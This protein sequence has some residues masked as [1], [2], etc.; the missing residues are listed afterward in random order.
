[1]MR[2]QIVAVGIACA[3]A[4][5]LAASALSSDDIQAQ[6]QALLA[7]VAELQQQLRV[8]QSASST[9]SDASSTDDMMAHPKL[10]V[11]S[12]LKRTLAQGAQGDDVSGLQ[13]YLI[14]GG[15]LSASSTGY[16][17]PLTARAVAK[18]QADEGVDS[19]G[20]FGPLSREH[21][22]IRCGQPGVMP[23]FSTSTP[24]CKPINY[25]PVLCSDGSAPQQKH[26]EAG[27]VVGYECP[28]TNFT[29]PPSCKA[30]N[31]G[32]NSCSRNTPGAPAA[33]TMRACFAAGKGY[34]IAYFDATTTSSI[35]DTV[36]TAEYAP[37]CGQPPG[38]RCEAGMMCPMYMLAPQTYSNRC[39]MSAAGA[40]LIHE[41][42]CSNASTTDS[43]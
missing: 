11:C 5:P 30:W 10:R 24:Q 22:K 33:C 4:V 18:W 39:M 8:M 31:D 1:M 9:I 15:Y 26:N 35:G 7:K 41:G 2:K 43:N 13:E 28:V 37:V 3:L 14:A 42:V 40:T 34:C 25:M 12:L 16:Y 38:P 17:G 23:P 36:C 6:I 19:V 21:L 20:V 32:C 29:P 27:C